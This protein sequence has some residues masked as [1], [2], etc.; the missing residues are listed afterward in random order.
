MLNL[1]SKDLEPL[2]YL[3]AHTPYL[4]IAPVEMLTVAFLLWQLV[5]KES[6]V[7][8]GYLT[9]IMLSNLAIGKILRHIRTQM[10]KKT[11]L[12]LKFV[13]DVI[14]GIRVIKMNVWEPLMERLIGQA[15]R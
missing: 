3:F 1:V 15:R 14:A 11:D 8:I 13:C 2:Q 9:I 10:T 6:V 12:R 7:S 4:L 5:G